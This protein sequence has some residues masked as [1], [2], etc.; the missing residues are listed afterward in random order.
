MAA[1]RAL[2]GEALRPSGK[3]S[4]PNPHEKLRGDRGSVSDD[5]DLCRDA[6]GANPSIVADLWEV[7]R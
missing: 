1:M 7:A 2:L 6:D 3:G 5:R 4:L